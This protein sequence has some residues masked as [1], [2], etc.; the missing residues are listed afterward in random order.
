MPA[1]AELLARL[2]TPIPGEVPSGPDLRY[3]ARYGAVKEARRE[4][5]DLPAGELDGPRKLAD[6]GQTVTLASQLLEKET[7]DLQLAAW[8]TEAL[9]RK[10]GIA[11]LL[12]GLSLLDGLLQQYWDTLHPEIEDDDLE[13]RSGPLEW[14]GARLDLAV[15]LAPIA[16]GGIS[17]LDYT[18]SRSIPTEQETEGNAAQ[19]AAREEAIEAGK[20]TPEQVDAQIEAAS[21]PFYRALL[22]DQTACLAAL[23]A[24]ET[25]SDM[26][27]GRDAPG[28]SAL[29]KALDEVRALVQGI[30]ARKLEVD[31][32]PV[33]E[34]DAGD[35]DGPVE[36]V[37]DD[38]TISS[39]VASARD[40]ANRI[41][42]SA[43][44]L[45]KENPANPA[46]YLL[47]RG[48]RWGELRATP[49]ELDP[50]LLEA[51]P[52]AARARLK[53]LLL[54]SRWAEL[55][56]QGEQLMATAQGRGWLDLQRY[57]LTACTQLGDAYDGV[58][59]V[60]RSELRALLA[61]LPQL[62]QMTLMDDTP[63]ANGETREWLAD[64]GLAPDPTELPD[65]AT[66]AADA[67]AGDAPPDD[68]TEALEEALEEEEATAS[69]GGLARAPQR[70]ARARTGSDPFTLARHE[71]T[72]GRPNHAIE[73]MVA[74]LARERSPRGRFVRQTQVAYLML[75]AGLEAVARPMLE[76]LVQI[77][78]ERSLE[79]WESGPLVAQPLALLCRV[80]DKLEIRE[81]DR[82]ELYLRVCR[83]DPLQA[84]GL[85]RG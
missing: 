34:S 22:A 72:L 2:L 30:L 31:P 28:F 49:G 78:D 36:A 67:E 19:R 71:L 9:L 44:F 66:S 62:P 63:T 57:T 68:G 8:L 18:T 12:T 6:W 43:R 73:L 7:K 25:T 14:I 55:L 13:L 38:G 23:D 82:D 16:G 33:D 4:D 35:G 26:R 1:N 56:E 29:R 17:A 32:D 69:N 39:E 84:L 52:T 24:L 70:R 74:Q 76:R 21:K 59:A 27:F 75:E 58:A 79:D 85:R 3:D 65:D 53:G 77:I 15:R 54:D 83:L 41:A 47:L 81:D 5:P 50:R 80:Y 11:G 64:E 37:S 60:V 61:A 40:A 48:F 20:R 46:P 45:R 51:P 42:A 10:E